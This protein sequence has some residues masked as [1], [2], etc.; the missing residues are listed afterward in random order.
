MTVADGSFSD[1]RLAL[2]G[3]SDTPVRI[4]NVEQALNGGDASADAIR[5][6][7]ALTAEGAIVFD[8]ACKL[9]L[10]GIVSKRAGSRY[11]SGP[12]RNWLKRLNP[13]F[14]RR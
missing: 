8:Y 2:F 10:E 1:V 5:F 11:R 4:A 12:T 13:E 3:I 9:G 7:E 6:S 14:Q